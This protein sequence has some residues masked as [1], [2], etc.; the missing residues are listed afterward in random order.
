[1][2]P[3]RA[4]FLCASLAAGILL[5]PCFPGCHPAAAALLGIT[6]CQSLAAFA[7]RRKEAWASLLPLLLVTGALI[8]PAPPVNS[9]GDGYA[10]KAVNVAGDIVPRPCGAPGESR[11][12]LKLT[13]DVR[14]GPD[15]GRIIYLC[16]DP[17]DEPPPWGSKIRAAGDLFV[18]GA[19]SGEISGALT[20]SEIE[21]LAG[22]SNPLQ[23]GSNF[24][25]RSILK[26]CRSGLS[27]RAGGLLAGIILGDYRC[28]GQRDAATLKRSGLIHLCSASGLHVGILLVIS[29]WFA[30]R[31]RMGRRVALLAQMP[32]LLIYAMAA[33]MTPPIVRSGL[34]AAVAAAAFFRAREFH[35]ISAM[36][37][38]ALLSLLLAPELLFNI[39]FQLT[40]LAAAG[41][42]MLTKPVA[43]T[44]HVEKSKAGLLFS[45]SVAAQAGILPLLLYHFGEFSLMAP[46]SNLLV[47]PLIPAVMVFGLGGACVA[48]LPVSLLH[49]LMWPLEI[50]LLAILRIS[51]VAASQAWA[52]VFNPGLPVVLFWTW[53]P[54]AWLTWLRRPPRLRRMRQCALCLALICTLVLWPGTP[55]RAGPTGLRIVFLDVGQ[56]D[57]VLVQG[58]QGETILIDGGPDSRVLVDK[59]R[60]YGIRSLDVLVLSHPHS[61]HIDGTLDM[62]RLWPIGLCVHNGDATSGNLESL[63]DILAERRTPV[64]SVAAGDLLQ[65]GEL[66]LTV[67]SPGTLDEERGNDNALVIRMEVDGISL[68]LAGDI[69]E[70]RERELMDAGAMLRSDMLKVPHHGGS[71]PANEDFF[72]AVKPVLGFIQ[73]G[74]DNSFGHPAL[75]TLKYLQRTGCRVFRTD[76]DGDIVV[77]NPDGR[78]I[79]ST[80]GGP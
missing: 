28:L 7:G 67:I 27:E 8:A 46:I 51:D 36:S 45:T 50:L 55:L 77:A 3:H 44:L 49:C 19:L 26:L 15:A 58:S 63:M 21:L 65:V 73:V 48:W 9:S 13:A 40:Y 38:L 76:T 11:V 33:G 79:V 66:K 52:V 47:I 53:Y 2:Y 23:R 59:L 17:R 43:E 10:L 69:G 35:I 57:A 25:R 71:S 72:R 61:D 62:A 42:I 14:G 64:R 16:L 31:L 20:C 80:Q 56:G 54:L 24:V 6:I 4:S 74:E 78:L 60:S 41:C 5:G 18:F 34:L 29:L 1:M 30:R 75:S 70:M 12:M 37:A 22:P 39:S 32:L 68:L